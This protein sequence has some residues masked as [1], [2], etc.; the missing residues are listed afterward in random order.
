MTDM[1]LQA[2]QGRTY[3]WYTGT[4]TFAFGEGISYTT[5][6]VGVSSVIPSNPSA[7]AH[8][9]AI[10][11]T[12]TGKVAAAEVVLVFFKVASLEHE[13]SELNADLPNKQLCNFG[14][15]PVLRPGEQYTL[16]F[17]IT[18]TEL[19]L[20]GWDGRRVVLPGKYTLDFVGS[21]GNASTE[22]NVTERTL[23]ETLPPP[24]PFNSTVIPEVMHI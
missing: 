9:F 2:G 6:D 19:V 24:P 14:R 8:S 1:A 4:P 10:L 15:T 17:M 23:L 13:P 7:P 22:V 21:N 11:V 20:V 3:K 18:A 16:H 12:N 5:F